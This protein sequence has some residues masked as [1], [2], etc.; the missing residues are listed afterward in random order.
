MPMASWSVRAGLAAGLVL[1]LLEPVAPAV[2]QAAPSPEI[3]NSGF[4][5]PPTGPAELP[6]WRAAGT[7]GTATI[8]RPARTG[9]FALQHNG[10]RAYTVT[11]TQTV[12]VPD[13]HYTLTAYAQS[14]GGQ[15]ANYLFAEPAGGRQ[16]RTAVPVSSAWTVV[17]VRGVEVRHGRLTIGLRTEAPQGGWTRLDDVRLT[18]GAPY[19]FLA[20]G[21]ITMLNW[22]ED[23][24]GRYYDERGRREDPLK[25]MAENGTDIVR[26]RLYN[27][28]GPDHPRVGYPGHYLP[29]GYQDEE[30]ILDLARR[31]TPY[32]MRIQLT[33]HYSDYWT[34]GEIQDIPKDWRD[35]TDLPRDQAVDKLESHVYDY[36]RYF[37]QRM[38]AQGTPPA[39]VSLGNEMQGGLLFPYGYSYTADGA[40]ALARFLKA[41]YRATKEVSPDTQVIIHI[42]DAGDYDEYRWFFGLLNRLGVPYD[43]IGSSYYPF[44][45]RRDIPTVVQFFD[46]ISREFNKKIMVME[47]G[48]NWNPVTHEGL[49]GQ[50]HDNGPVPYGETPAGQRD[51]LY[52]LFAALKSVPDGA[53]IGDLYWDPVMIPAP[54]VGWEVGEPNFVSNTTLFDF[55]GRALPALDAYRYNVD[56]GR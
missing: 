4:E 38:A 20:G 48:I 31:A 56:G 29:E 1:S 25:I 52:E 9:A 23:S 54:G 42:T 36:T 26:L 10:T 15:R 49:E 11:T 7:R 13:G 24:G 35:V 14:G 27:D 17:T 18:A 44:W 19:D 33:F 16:A 22:V 32:G 43:L 30:D 21:D 3:R 34:N 47:T 55:T 39:F 5:T 12:R 46:T 51:F 28:T 41:G 45:T 50:L 40:P 37:L 6:G 2:A 53:V 8:A